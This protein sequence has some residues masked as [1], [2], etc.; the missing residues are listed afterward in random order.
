M[1][2]HHQH[3]PACPASVSRA[4]RARYH[5][6]VLYGSAS[7]H[8]NCIRDH[9]E[10]FRLYS[11]FTI[12]YVDALDSARCDIDLMLFDAVIIHYCCTLYRKNFISP[13]YFAAL[14]A[15]AGPKIAFT[16][17]EYDNTNAIHDNLR[18]LGVDVYYTCIPDTQIATVFPPERLPGVTIVPTLTGYVPLS[19]KPETA[20][21]PLAQRPVT[22]G[23]RGRRLPYRYGELGWE[24]YYIGV[25]MKEICLERGVI[26]DIEWREE[27]RLY[28]DRWNDFIE[29]CRVMLGSESG[30]NIFDLDGSLRLR[31]EDALR[32]Q[33]DLTYQQARD[34]FLGG[35][36]GRHALAGMASPRLFEAVASK[37]ALVLFEGQYSGV[38]EPETH[39]IP[40]KKDFSNID[41]VMG[42]IHDLQFLEAMVERAYDQLIRSNRYSYETFVTEVSDR[43]LTMMGPPKGVTFYSVMLGARRGERPAATAGF[44]SGPPES[45]LPAA[46]ARLAELFPGEIRQPAAAAT[47]GLRR[48]IT[49]RPWFT[50]E[51]EAV[52]TALLNWLGVTELH[53]LEPLPRRC[54]LFIFGTAAGARVL[55]REMRQTAGLHL[56]GFIDIDIESDGDG[57]DLNGLPVCAIDRFAA[58]FPG[59]TPVILSNRYVLENSHALLT[60]G[61]HRLFNGL[62]L[63]WRLTGAG[64]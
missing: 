26:C 59:D 47:T 6:L 15:F 5:V 20:L 63:I 57:R 11:G 28:G 42:R 21:T 4:E 27:A 53:T 18:E 34:R 38:V 54:P 58:D 51:E 16:Q 44:L 61:C 1:T 49:S 7:I 55:A 39:Y 2:L 23:Y 22:V 25:R 62:P 37:T 3:R 45:I 56:A 32:E 24:K 8:T 12:H 50:V 48:F 40:L 35:E 9:L 36:E 13:S 14:A 10:S 52:R 31:L 19:I 17:D 46:G 41:Q 64:T 30:C 33:P 60:R 29:R 43:L